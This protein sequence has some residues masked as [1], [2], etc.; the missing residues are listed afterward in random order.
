VAAF[1]NEWLK[2][3]PENAKLW[4]ALIILVLP[5]FII[6]YDQKTCLHETSEGILWPAKRNHASDHLNKKLR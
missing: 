3:V 5:V 2:A 6:T 4:A 1:F